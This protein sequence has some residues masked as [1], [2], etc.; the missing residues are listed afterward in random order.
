MRGGVCVIG[1]N[2]NGKLVGGEDEF[3]K[4]RKVDVALKSRTTPRNAHLFPSL[5]Q[6]PSGEL[7]AD[8]G[9]I[10]TSQPRFPNW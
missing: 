2:L 7:A 3:Q 9:A 5:A 4:E 1:M 8:D 10:K 6:R